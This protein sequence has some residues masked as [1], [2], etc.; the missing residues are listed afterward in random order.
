MIEIPPASFRDTPYGEVDVAAL[1]RLRTS[2]DTSQLLQLVDRLDA[3]LAELGGVA[4]VR[5]ELLKLHAMA[6]TLLVEGAPLTVPNENACIWSEAES[7]QQD[8]EVL[9]GW[10]RSAQAGISPLINLAPDHEQ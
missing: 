9:A 5:D 6:L 10:V 2:F 4:A 7:L 1:D 3:C 8:L